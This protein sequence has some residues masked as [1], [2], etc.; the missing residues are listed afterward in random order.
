MSLKSRVPMRRIAAAARANQSPADSAS[1]LLQLE[2]PD[3]R[4]ER[5]DRQFDRA[6]DFAVLRDAESIW[7]HDCARGR[8][9][10][11]RYTSAESR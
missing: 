3:P 8:R 5:C 2:T 4:P 7:P 9:F 6:P 10:V 1:R 11:V